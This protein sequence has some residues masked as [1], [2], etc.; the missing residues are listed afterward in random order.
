MPS[1][2]ADTNFHAFDPLPGKPFPTIPT[3]GTP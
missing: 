1:Q 3:I 2:L